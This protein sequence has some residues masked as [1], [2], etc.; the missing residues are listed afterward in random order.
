MPSPEQTAELLRE[1]GVKVV[2]SAEADDTC[3]MV[4]CVSGQRYYFAD[5]VFT[6]CDDCG[7]SI[8]HRPYA[9]KKPPKLCFK[10]ATKRIDE[11][12]LDGQN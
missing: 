10:C 2:S 11:G 6:V 4:V 8:Q 5:N 1:L 9:P 12:K 3:D 7:G